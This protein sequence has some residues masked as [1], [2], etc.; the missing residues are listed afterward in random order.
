MTSDARIDIHCKGKAELTQVIETQ[1]GPI[2]GAVDNATGVHRFLGIPYAL[3]PI[4]ELRWQPPQPVPAWKTPLQALEFGMPAA[5]NPS[6]LFEIRG[7]KGE[8]PECEDC[9]YL[10]IYAPPATQPR[11]R[12]LPVMLWLHGGSF[13]MGSGCQQIYNGCHLTASGRAIVVTM[14]YRLGALGFLRL[15][16]I[17]DI[18]SSGNEGLQDQIAALKWIH[19]NIAAFGGDSNNITL[20]GESAGAMSI[21]ALLAVPRCRGLFHRAIVQ[22]GNPRAMHSCERA[23]NLAQAFTKHLEQCNG[24]QSLRQASTQSLLQAQQAVL[25]DPR[26]ERSWGQLPFKPVLDG[27]L[28]SVDP[29][30]ALQDGSSAEVDLLLG[31]NLE[32]WNLFSAVSPEVFTLDDR[33]IRRRLEW[34]LPRKE[35]D[36]LLDHYYHV[37]ATMTGDP[38]PAWSRAWNLLL[39]D[40]VFT[41]PGLRLL[42]S[43]SGTRYHYHF[44]QPLAAHPLLGACHAVELAYVFGT[45]GEASLQSLYGGEEGADSLSNAMRGAWLNFAESGDP[46]GNWPVFTEGHSRRFGDHPAARSFDT[47]ELTALWQHIPD[48]LLNG[49][50]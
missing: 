15:R 44:A 33:Q 32:E 3:P 34:L 6:V 7:P 16:D 21:A 37:A 36:P 42:Q 50:L 48:D 30:M 38:W 9:L 18:P 29:L 17:S 4:G 1:A 20:F 41:L 49:Y 5:Q 40:M 25:S 35:L 19:A 27:D 22:S 14:N 39:T 28:L 45:H 2:I 8:L 12:K 47:A 13:Y 31:S 24:G 46:G 10:N 26:M 43:H 23:N 11:D